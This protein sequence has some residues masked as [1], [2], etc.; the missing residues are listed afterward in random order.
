M[1]RAAAVT[2][3]LGVMPAG[4]DVSRVRAAATR[5]IEIEP[6]SWERTR[7]RPNRK[8]RLLMADGDTAC[9]CA[10]VGDTDRART[11]A[12]RPAP[13]T[14]QCVQSNWTLPT[15]KIICHL[16]KVGQPTAL[17]SSRQRI[18]C[19]LPNNPGRWQREAVGKDVAGG[20]ERQSA[21]VAAWQVAKKSWWQRWRPVDGLHL[22]PLC[23]LPSR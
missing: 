19:R 2:Y 4:I 16:P 22:R 23:H 15:A 6:R 5:W 14:V 8:A 11:G 9:G 1:E 3:V 10:A 18:L 20:K 13:I 7:T 17:K 21:K 12:M